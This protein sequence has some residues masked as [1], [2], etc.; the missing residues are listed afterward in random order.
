MRTARARVEALE[1]RLAEVEQG[2]KTVFVTFVSPG[3]NGPV[4]HEPVA[5]RDGLGWTL[6]RNPSEDVEAFRERAKQLC[7]QPDRGAAVLIDILK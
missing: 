6:A 3:E 4:R 1:T 5:V 2:P 7:P